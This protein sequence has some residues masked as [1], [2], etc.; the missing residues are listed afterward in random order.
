M[1]AL[2]K[3]VKAKPDC[4]A[5]F[6]TTPSTCMDNHCFSVMSSRACKMRFLEG[7]SDFNVI[8]KEESAGTYNKVQQQSMDLCRAQS[9]F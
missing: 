7:G 8:G 5:F 3:M 4:A 2:N 9:C 6:E 1:S